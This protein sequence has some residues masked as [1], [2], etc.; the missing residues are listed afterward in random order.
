M[1][2]AIPLID[3][4]LFA[5]MQANV[6]PAM[7]GR[8]FMLMISL[9]SLTSPIGLAIAGPVSDLVGLQVWYVVGGLLCGAIGL[10]SFFI[11]VMLNIE[12]NGHEQAPAVPGATLAVEPVYQEVS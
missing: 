10:A 8:V 12:Q 6:A 4:P 5:I 3:G 7:Q 2:L 9:I 1:G 11:P